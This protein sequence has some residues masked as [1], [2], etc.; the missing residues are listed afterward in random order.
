MTTYREVRAGLAFAIAFLGWANPASSTVL[1]ETLQ[2]ATFEDGGIAQGSFNFDTGNGDFSNI[3]VSVSGGNT[4][5]LTPFTYTSANSHVFTLDPSD[6]QMITNAGDRYIGLRLANPLA[7]GG[8]DPFL[9]WASHQDGFGKAT[10][11]ECNN[12]GSYRIFVDGAVAAPEP[13]TLLLLGL[14]LLIT[15]RLRARSD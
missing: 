12:C 2:N 1:H 6:F 14:G 9:L 8:V 13:G 11:F 4:P 7:D 3:N 5:F 10:G 15:G